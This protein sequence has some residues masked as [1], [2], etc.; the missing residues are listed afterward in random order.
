M[1]F[2]PR[3]PRQ[4]HRTHLAD[5]LEIDAAAKRR[6]TDEYDAATPI[7]LDMMQVTAGP[8]ESPDHRVHEYLR[9]SL[10]LPG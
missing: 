9:R 2:T 6:L 4:P 8:K 3:H 5:A 7:S 10:P 1:S